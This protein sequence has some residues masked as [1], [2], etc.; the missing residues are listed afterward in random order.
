M[1]TW[2]NAVL[3][4]NGA[5]VLLYAENFP[6]TFVRGA[7]LN[8]AMAKW[9]RELASYLRW[10]DGAPPGRL[11]VRARIIQEKRS[12]LQVEDAD[13]D[14][15]FDSEQGPLTQADYAALRALCLRS[16]EDFLALYES[17]PDRDRPLS[18]PRET[19]YGPVPRTAAEIYQHTKNVNNYYFGE[20]G[21]DV[22][23]APDIL[24]CRREGFTLLEGQTGFLDNRVFDGSYGEQWSLRKVLRRF[25]WHD[26]IHARALT[27]LAARAWG[28]NGTSDPFC[29]ALEP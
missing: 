15:L 18:P 14:V 6:G 5:G 3:E 23:N 9:P 11:T 4:T 26:R 22:G 1:E 10:R 7:S 20:I 21:V 8:E 24:Q 28:R 25:L 13:S 29:F 17:V 19:F 27:R 12:N 16:A 2:I